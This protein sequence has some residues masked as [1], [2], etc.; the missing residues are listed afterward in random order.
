MLESRGGACASAPLVL[1]GSTSVLHRRGAAPLPWWRVGGVQGSAAAAVS[2]ACPAGC[3]LRLGGHEAAACAV[4]WAAVR[5][6]W[7]AV[8]ARM[9][10]SPHR[11]EGLRL[12]GFCDTRAIPA[13]LRWT[14]DA[15]PVAR[16]DSYERRTRE[17]CL[18]A[19]AL[20]SCSAQFVAA[21]TAR[22]GPAGAAGS[23]AACSPS[24]TKPGGA[25]FLLHPKKKTGE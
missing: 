23:R 25:P 2:E 7:A 24:R 5:G 9:A 15:L 8:R 6:D 21:S 3:V 13:G 16:T 20:Q 10:S 18:E 11:N 17:A 14:R 19:I 12:V 1:H 22:C 4:L